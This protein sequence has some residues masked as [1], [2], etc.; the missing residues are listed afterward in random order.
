[1]SIGKTITSSDDLNNIKETGIYGITTSPTNAPES[2]TYCTLIV[3]KTSDSDVRQII[4][5]FSSGGQNIYMRAFGT[6]WTQWAKFTGTII[7]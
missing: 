7:T 2:V 3:Q 1:M 4:Y 6:A 5:R